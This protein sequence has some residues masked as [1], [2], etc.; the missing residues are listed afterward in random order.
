MEKGKR[1]CPIY[2]L[3]VEDEPLFL[4]YCSHSKFSKHSD[5]FLDVLPPNTFVLRTLNT[6][7]SPPPPPQT[8]TRQLA[9]SCK[10][11]FLTAK[12]ARHNFVAF[13]IQQIIYIKSNQS[14][15]IL[16]HSQNRPTGDRWIKL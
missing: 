15:D 3:A 16:Q 11:H 6:K 10:I 14:S 2:S 4:L 7:I 5:K 1:I 8:T 12:R 13:N 9:E